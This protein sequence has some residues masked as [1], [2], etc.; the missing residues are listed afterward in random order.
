MLKILK[1]YSTN[2]VK[3]EKILCLKRKIFN[4]IFKFF[5]DIDFE[6]IFRIFVVY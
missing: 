3:N 1:K 4:K 5:Y 2:F 6:I